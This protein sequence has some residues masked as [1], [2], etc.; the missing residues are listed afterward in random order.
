MG[1]VR[2]PQL[3]I[4]QHRGC[5]V[6][7]VVVDVN[8]PVTLTWAAV[9]DFY[10][11]AN[12]FPHGGPVLSVLDKGDS[13]RAMRRRIDFTGP[14]SLG[15]YVIQELQVCNPVEMVL[16]T[17][18]VASRLPGGT[19][20]IETTRVLPQATGSRIELT[21]GYKAK[22]WFLFLIPIFRSKVRKNI[23][24]AIKTM[25]VPA[26]GRPSSLSATNLAYQTPYQLRSFDASQLPQWVER[27]LAPPKR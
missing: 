12:Y 8:H 5:G 19:T 22:W 24:M 14:K 6:L 2:P 20:W 25:R 21:L 7:K 11:Y 4:L 3:V 15:A 10:G 13:Q 23:E 18:S 9:S 1:S 16:I 17:R 27:V 26:E